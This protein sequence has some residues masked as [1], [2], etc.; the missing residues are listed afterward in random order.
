MKKL[1]KI[2]KNISS[3]DLIN[4]LD[5]YRSDVAIV[6]WYTPDQIKEISKIDASLEIIEDHWDGIKSYVSNEWIEE[7]CNENLSEMS[8]VA[9]YWGLEELFDMKS[10]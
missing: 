6:L 1:N 3:E 9:N 10:N 8:F 2:L 7:K 5:D 4:Y